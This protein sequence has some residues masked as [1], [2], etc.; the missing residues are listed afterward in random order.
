MKSTLLGAARKTYLNTL[1]IPITINFYDAV[2]NPK[3]IQN[4]ETEMF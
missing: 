4:R 1:Y 3:N 2:T